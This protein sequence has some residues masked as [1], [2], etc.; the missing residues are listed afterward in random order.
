MIFVAPSIIIFEP[1]SC[2]CHVISK[3]ILG[4]FTMILSLLE[5]LFSYLCLFLII[6]MCSMFRK[7]C[8][9]IC[10][11]FRLVLDQSMYRRKFELNSVI[12][13]FIC[14]NPLIAS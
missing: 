6:N 10:W 1:S 4:E 2:Y 12:F 11:F 3:C 5:I 7:G 8:M 14:L 9:C 13:I